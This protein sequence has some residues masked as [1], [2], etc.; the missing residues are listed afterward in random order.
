[1]PTWRPSAP[2][3]FLDAPAKHTSN[4][5]HKLLWRVKSLRAIL[6]VTPCG[7]YHDRCHICKD[8]L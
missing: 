4:D 2:D 3:N 1:M 7:G 5:I 6:W 8:R